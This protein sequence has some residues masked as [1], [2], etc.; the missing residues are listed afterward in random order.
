MYGNFMKRRKFITSASLLAM[1]TPLVSWIKYPVS[2]DRITLIGDSITIGYQ[3][4]LPLYLDSQVEIW[5]PEESRVNSFDILGAADSWFKESGARLVHVNSGLEDLKRI[6]FTGYEN[7]VPLDAYTKNVERIIKYI[8]RIR[9]E[10]ILIWATT[11]PV[12]QQEE[13]TLQEES[14]KFIYNPED[15]IAYNMALRSTCEKLGVPVNDL[16]KF[17]MAGEPSRIMEEDGIHFTEFGYELLAEQV[18]AA[19]QVFLD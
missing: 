12:I 15:V 14:G 4:Y 1:G 3:P 9:P 16:Y 18:A 5:S 19:I 17:V 2:L 11:T 7:L 8:H 6:P 10:I 13:Q